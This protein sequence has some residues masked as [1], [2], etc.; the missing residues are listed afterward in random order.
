VV[1]E[2][3]EQRPGPGLD[4]ASGM[5]RPRGCSIVRKD[6][7]D[8]RDHPGRTCRYPPSSGPLTPTWRY[9]L[10]HTQPPHSKISVGLKKNLGANVVFICCARTPRFSLPPAFGVGK[11]ASVT[12]TVT[13]SYDIVFIAFL[14]LCHSVTVKYWNMVV[15]DNDREKGHK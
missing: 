15:N 11:R 8:S 6:E 9:R 13:D 12:A 14:V 7:R 2:V 4:R 3:C 10:G 5:A 1:R